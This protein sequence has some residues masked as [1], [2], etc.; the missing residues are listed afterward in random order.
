MT[1]PAK[2][3]ILLIEDEKDLGTLYVEILT[4]EGYDVTWAKDGEQGL[5]K[6]QNGGYDLVLLDIKM[7]KMDG[8]QVLEALTQT[9]KRKNGP[10][11]VL[12]QFSHETLIKKALKLG[13]RGYLI[14]SSLNPEQTLHEVRVYLARGKSGD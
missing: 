6:L 13:A 5:K 14:K 4:D 7:P 1:N 3:K 10:I 12:S 8:L 11:V 2:E 9:D